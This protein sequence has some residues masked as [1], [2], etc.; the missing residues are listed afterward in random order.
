MSYDDRKT[1]PEQDDV[2]TI[3]KT[4]DSQFLGIFFVKII[5]SHHRLKSG[6]I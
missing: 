4:E 5:N 1:L 6:N 2:K 3:R